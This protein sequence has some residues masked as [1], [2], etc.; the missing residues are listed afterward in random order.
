LEASSPTP[1][2]KRTKALREAPAATGN[3]G[4]RKAAR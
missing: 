1:E 4:V 2:N 3:P